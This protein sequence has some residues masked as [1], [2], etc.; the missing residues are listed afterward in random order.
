M[1]NLLNSVR[2]LVLGVLASAGTV[3]APVIPAATPVPVNTPI[4]KSA[5][6][7]SGSVPNVTASP[8][9][10]TYP[11]S[12]SSP[13]PLNGD[14]YIYVQGTYSYWGQSIKYLFLI[15]KAGGSFSGSLQGAC[16]AQGGGEYEGEEGGK[17]W[18]TVSGKCKIV[19]L[20][21]T[22]S[23]KFSGKLYPSTKTMIIDAENS[24]IHGLTV[25]YN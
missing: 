21:A 5:T 15:P 10:T 4:V 13:L 18:G 20:T 6:P 7:S 1:F 14:N 2:T 22:G 25:K 23:T 24:P 9:S 12:A 17:V 8:N 19:A 3:L 16:E 11:S